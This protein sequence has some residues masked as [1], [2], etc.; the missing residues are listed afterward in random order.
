MSSKIR[1]LLFGQLP[2]GLENVVG[3]DEGMRALFAG[4]S[5][6]PLIPPY[7]KQT[8]IRTNKHGAWRGALWPFPAVFQN[9]G[10]VWVIAELRIPYALMLLSSQ[11]PERVVRRSCASQVLPKGARSRLKCLG[12]EEQT[13][14]IIMSIFW[15]PGLAAPNRRKGWLLRGPAGI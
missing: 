3:M 1:I 7:L 9:S 14:G 13:S 12:T 8:N 10:S 6:S 2:R 5:V 4:G 11:W 15:G